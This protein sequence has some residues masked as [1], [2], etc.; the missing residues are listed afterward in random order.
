M[1]T[2]L[3]PIVRRGIGQ[4][5]LTVAPIPLFVV[6]SIWA[7]LYAANGGE[8]GVPLVGALMWMGATLEVYLIF[9]FCNYH[10]VVRWPGLEW[11]II[12]LVLVI[13]GAVF[14]GWY[15]LWIVGFT[16]IVLFLRKVMIFTDEVK[17][18]RV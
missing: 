9:R 6:G 5:V 13:V 15:L 18:Q 16:V 3:S 2:M 17:K 7:V 11:F 1:K 14:L 12:A 4:W 8:D 10:K